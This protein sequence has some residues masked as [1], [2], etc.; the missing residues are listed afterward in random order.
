MEASAPTRIEASITPRLAAT[1]MFSATLAPGEISGTSSVF[2]TC[3]TSPAV[4]ILVASERRLDEESSSSSAAPRSVAPSQNYIT[5]TQALLF[6]DAPI[7]SADT[8]CYTNTRLV[9]CHAY[10]VPV[11]EMSSAYMQP[12]L[13]G[14]HPRC[15]RLHSEC[16]A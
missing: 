1:A 5:R 2:V 16:A 15:G 7:Q 11:T 9:R 4:T 8:Q 12:L 6:P 13:P 14:L 10:A 3:V